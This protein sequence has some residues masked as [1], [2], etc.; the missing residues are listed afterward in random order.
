MLQAA[1]QR[2]CN[3]VE[4]SKEPHHQPHHLFSSHWPLFGPGKLPDNYT[5]DWCLY[6]I[7]TSKIQ[8]FAGNIID[9]RHEVMSETFKKTMNSDIRNPYTVNSSTP[10]SMDCLL[11]VQNAC[12]P[13]K[14][15]KFPKTF[16]R[17]NTTTYLSVLKRGNL[18]KTSG[19]TLGIANEV[20]SSC[21]CIYGSDGTPA[22]LDL[23][24]E[25]KEWA[26]SGFEDFG[27][28]FFS[29][30][31]NLSSLIV[32]IKLKLNAAAE[33]PFAYWCHCPHAHGPCSCTLC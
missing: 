9:L 12:I 28:P 32:I 3:L 6:K 30:Q 27:F 13:L 20:L 25:S 16:A 4:D 19:I 29:K 33:S 8:G 26:I 17:D 21:V 23:V 15:M 22:F 5:Y 1:W 31:G 11:K 10:Q 24:F 14:E 2:T 18:G 7:D